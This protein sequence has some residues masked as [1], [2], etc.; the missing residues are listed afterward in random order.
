MTRHS[1]VRLYLTLLA[2]MA[3]LIPSRDT[4]AEQRLYLASASEKKIDT[5][6]I[7]ANTGALTK[8]HTIQIPG[9]AGPM[10][11]SPGKDLI[12]AAMT[13]GKS[14][15]VAT[16]QRKENGSLAMIGV[17]KIVA[18]APYITTNRA[19]TLILAA[20]YGP[21]EVSVYRLKNNVVNEMTD[22]QQTFKTAHCIEVDASGKFV[23]VPHTS[24]NRVYQFKLDDKAGKLIPNDPAYV[25]GPDEDHMYHQPRHIAFHPKL[26]RAYTS[27]ERGGGITAWA[28]DPK[29][30]KLS[31]IQT[32]STLPKDYE[33][34]SAAAD[35]R[36]TPNGQFVYVSN[37]DVTKRE[38]G[39]QRDTLAG[40]QIDQKT[41]KLTLVGYYSTVNFPRS[42]TID[43][44][45]RFVYAAGQRSHDLA[46][47]QIDAKSGALKHTKTYNVGKG[48]IW[49]MTAMD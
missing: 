8:Q 18:R 37:R 40:F 36:I 13:E 42:F 31:K 7:N 26:Q 10:V 22:H 44:T 27:N 38:D 49:V 11:F 47:Y 25:D 3:L 19:G 34:G 17:G 30:G 16:L 2:L 39:K 28:F 29:T 35:I 32:L 43:V 41:G 33:G 1:R 6:V 9:N 20:H 12:Y 45:G 5:Y 4:M 14:A 24:P 21:G 48:P 15:K 46:A 23:F